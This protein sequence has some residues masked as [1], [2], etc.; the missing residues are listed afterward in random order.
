LASWSKKP[1]FIDK[2]KLFFKKL[3]KKII[4][5]KN[6]QKLKNKVKGTTDE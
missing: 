4:G 5:K 1:S 2:I 6:Y 3:L